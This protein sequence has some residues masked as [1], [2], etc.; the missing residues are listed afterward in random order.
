MRI[1]YD[2]MIFLAV[3]FT[4]FWCV[5]ALALFGALLFP[6][7]YEIIVVFALFEFLFQ[8]GATIFMSARPFVPLAC[9]ALLFIFLIEWGRKQ[10]RKRT[11]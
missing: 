4:P 7:W 6:R 2:I 10:I 1:A 8:G 3:F 9:F 11:I 5:L